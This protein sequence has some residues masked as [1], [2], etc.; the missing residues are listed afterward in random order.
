MSMRFI[1]RS[2]VRGSRLLRSQKW[3]FALL[4]G[5]LLA[6]CTS[7]PTEV[8]IQIPTPQGGT[9]NI[10]GILLTAGT[11][12]QPYKGGDLYLGRVIHGGQSDSPPFVAFSPNENIK[13]Y[14]RN[15]E[16]G[17]FVFVNVPPGEYALV[18]DLIVMSSAIED[19]AT[20]NFIIIR[21]AA[22]QTTDAGVIN[23]P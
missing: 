23:V 18:L 1:Q 5:V 17:E 6:A 2:R 22:D 19:P 7:S 8:P 13:T 20:H 12:H 14:S 3:V 9:G 16:T 15:E 10:K 4:V 21:A 11:D